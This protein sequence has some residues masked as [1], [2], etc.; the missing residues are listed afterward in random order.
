M[1][2]EKLKQKGWVVLISIH[3]TVPF[4]SLE[5]F[6]SWKISQTLIIS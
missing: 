1:E 5:M 2:M 6:G 4:K 3:F